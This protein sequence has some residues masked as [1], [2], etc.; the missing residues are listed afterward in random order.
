MFLIKIKL[1]KDI[2]AIT[3]YPFILTNKNKIIDDYT[4]NHEKIHIKQQKELLIF[5]FY[6]W[7][8]I[9]YLIKMIKYKNS[10]TAYMNISFEREAYKHEQDLHYLDKRKLFSFIKYI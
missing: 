10:H 3:L 8:G 1:P 5:L 4:L 6:I 9:E 2:I 7:Y